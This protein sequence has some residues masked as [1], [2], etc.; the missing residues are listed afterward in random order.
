MRLKNPYGK[1]AIE[2]NSVK[3]EGEVIVIK[4]EALGTMPVTVQVT[5]DD[6]WEARQFMSW[7]VLRK[8]PVMFVK[9]WWRSRKRSKRAKTGGKPA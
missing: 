4:G 5:V 3:V 1:V 7:P 8:A 9:G 2:V 6:M